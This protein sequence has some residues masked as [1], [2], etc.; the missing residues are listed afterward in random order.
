M[1]LYDK[2]NAIGEFGYA[3]ELERQNNLKSWTSGGDKAATAIAASGLQDS[4]NLYVSGAANIGSM[5]AT[6]ASLGGPVGAGI[7]AGIGVITTAIQFSDRKKARREARRKQE[8]R[9]KLL[10]AQRQDE[11]NFRKRSLAAEREKRAYSR[12]QDIESSRLQAHQS[13]YAKFTDMLNRNSA[14][15]SSMIEK[16]YA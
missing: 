14:F 4:S 8:R 11:L 7:G 12:E 9:D 2:Y 3:N 15:K 16:G 5:A 13:A 1:N 6:G 10:A